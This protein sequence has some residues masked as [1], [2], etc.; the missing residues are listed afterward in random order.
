MNPSPNLIQ[1]GRK[2]NNDLVFIN[3]FHEKRPATN[4][5]AEATFRQ[6]N[7]YHSQK[8]EK[9][10]W[11][12]E[13]IKKREKLRRRKRVVGYGMGLSLRWQFPTSNRSGSSNP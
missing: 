4:I 6:D 1:T 11:R 12:T 8:K 9:T 7:I 13:E 3:F 10:G 5:S 2:Q